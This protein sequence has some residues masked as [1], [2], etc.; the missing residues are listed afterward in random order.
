MEAGALA[1]MHRTVAPAARLR[2]DPDVI[3]APSAGRDARRLGHVTTTRTRPS[4]GAARRLHRRLGLDGR[5][6]RAR[7]PARATSRPTRS[8]PALMARGR[9]RAPCSC[10]A[11][12]PTAARRSPPRSSTAR[13][14]SSGEQ[15][16]NRLPTEQAVALRPDHRRLGGER[17]AHR[18]R[19]RRQRAAA[20]RR[21]GRRRRRSARNVAAAVARARRAGPPSTRS[22]SRTATARRSGC[23]RC[24]ARPTRDVA[25]YPLDVLGAESEGMIGYLLEQE[26]RQRTRRP[27]GRHAAHAGDRRRR[28]PRVRAPDQADRPG[29]RRATTASGWPP[30]A[31]GRSRP[32][33]TACAASS[34][35]PEPR[36]IVE[37]PTI[38][39]LV[40][41]G[42]LVVCVGGGGIPVDRRPRRPPARRRG[43]HR[44]GP[45]RRAARRRPRRRRAAAAHRRRRASTRTGAP[46]TPS[47][48]P[49]DSPRSCASSTL[50]RRL[51][52]PEGRGRVPLRRARPAACAAI[53]ALDDAEAIL[54]GRAGTRIEPSPSTTTR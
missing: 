43:G 1:G 39:L 41:A 33:A 20:A 22:S 40:E 25:P 11:C 36:S 35:S 53:G 46:P 14:R 32:T 3:A 4:Q 24:R 37:L 31:A 18:R 2:P 12:P 27:A 29:L 48:R 50:R 21:A 47:T 8:T 38:R 9:A 23:S 49:R 6:S 17:H 15:A 28:R 10:T 34:P 52:G 16:A 44:Q 5:G 51:D 42:V 7:A 19:P 30:S 54:A 45:R 26:L 13:S